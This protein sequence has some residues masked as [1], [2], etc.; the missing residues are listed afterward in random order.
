MILPPGVTA[1]Y[2]HGTYTAT[3]GSVSLGLWIL[4]FA[5]VVVGLAGMLLPRLPGAGSGS[6]LA[7]PDG[8]TT[9]QWLALA[10]ITTL[11]LALRTIRLDTEPW[12]DEIEMLVRYVPLDLRQ[13]ISTYDSQNHHPLYT[14][15]AHFTWL[16]SGGADWGI[17]VPAVVAGTA[18]V[19]ALGRFGQRVTGPVESLLGALVL[20]VSYHAVWFS[21]NARGYT[22][23]LLLTILATGVFLR[24]LAGEGPRVRLAWA[25]GIL[26][27]LATYTHLTAALVAVGHAMVVLV[28]VSWRSRTGRQAGQWALIA[29]ALGGLLT[30]CL[31][32]PMLPQ[33][34][35][36]LIAPSPTPVEVEWTSPVWML[37]EGAR[38]LAG[39]IP[40]GLPAALV[41]VTVLGFG[42]ASLWRRSRQAALAMFLPVLVTAGAVMAT[43]HNLWPRFFFF[44]AGFLVLA[45]IEG[46][47]TIVRWLVRWHPEQVAVAGACAVAAVSLLTVPRAW[48]PKQAFRAAHDWVESQRIPGDA[49]VALDIAFHP[50]F[51]RESAP[52]W[53]LT[54]F[55]GLLGDVE[56]TAGRTWIVYT[57]PARL[58]A[59]SPDAWARIHGPAYR[60]IRVFPTT[61]GGGE[62]H[63][64]RRDPRP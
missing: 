17:R 23:I 8:F 28:T 61:V 5:L 4:K 40:G 49:V 3:L 48:Q 25:Y 14:I 35:H 11:A 62:I 1:S 59:I 63:V 54:S 47:F 7:L 32:A 57:L 52:T 22:T 31:Y 15:A 30:I 56:R 6:V 9:S 37:R 44:A 2:L 60:E 24:L 38:A 20:A 55:D 26:I 58:Q 19:F 43:G 34:V 16:A 45:A 10:G 21:Q 36:Q 18:A 13:L 46:G 27:A 51:L 64:L 50:Y 39:G 12:L 29:I 53:V 33:L 41:A 42:I